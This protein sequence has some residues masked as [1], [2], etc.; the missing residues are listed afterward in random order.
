LTAIRNPWV[1]RFRRTFWKI[2]A[3]ALGGI[4]IHL[5]VYLYAVIFFGV[6]LSV[7]TTSDWAVEYLA[8]L[9]VAILADL[10][11][12]FGIAQSRLGRFLL[13]T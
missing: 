12:Y 8:A 5:V 11:D 6:R 13:G 10:L 7:I 2:Y 4:S 3:L 9:T 1:R